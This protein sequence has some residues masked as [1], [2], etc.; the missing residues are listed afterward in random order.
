VA[1]VVLRGMRSGLASSR[2]KVALA[3]SSLVLV[4]VSHTSA[5]SFAI[6]YFYQVTA[7]KGRVVGTTFHGLPRW[8]RQS[9]AK[10][11][12]KLALYEYRWPR[13]SWDDASLIKRV[14]TDNHGNFD[15]G[16]VRTGHYT[17]R[18]DDNDLFDVELKDLPLVTKSV[19]ID[20]SP[21]YPDCTGGHGF[22]VRTK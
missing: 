21:V 5:C 6:G 4:L 16:L 10:K 7:L 18:I 15:L 20:V 22:V 3:V 17:L 9:F 14:E 2:M 12:A 11:H 1:A 8:L 13:A 19:T